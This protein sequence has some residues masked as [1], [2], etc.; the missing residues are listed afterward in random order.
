M[1]SKTR[2]RIST[3]IAATIA[4]T[5]I[6]SG[7]VTT[8]L[9]SPASANDDNCASYQ[10][11]LLGSDKNFWACITRSGGNLVGNGHTENGNTIMWIEIC[12]TDPGG[13][14]GTHE[15]WEV[16]VPSVSLPH[17]SYVTTFH[18]GDGRGSVSSQSIKI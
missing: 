14:Y 7:L 13:C 4:A 5:A 15:G 12:P 9:A 1:E 18:Y 8:A 11:G 16:S 2:R 17:G 3:L 10:S 6:S